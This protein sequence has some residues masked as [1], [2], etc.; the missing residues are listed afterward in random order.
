M[1]RPLIN[2]QVFLICFILW[3]GQAPLSIQAMQQECRPESGSRLPIKAEQLILARAGRSQPY[4]LEFIQ[5]IHESG[6]TI[7]RRYDHP[8]LSR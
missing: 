7:R 1:R 8:L 6:I 3:L 2:H 5:G 4:A